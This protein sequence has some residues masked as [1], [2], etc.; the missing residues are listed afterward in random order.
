MIQYL[1]TNEHL[2][3]N[4][5]YHVVADQQTP[6][7]IE[8]NSFKGSVQLYIHLDLQPDD[9]PVKWYLSM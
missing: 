8:T 6:A 1:A 4:N 5:H 2:V 7:V 3:H 9:A